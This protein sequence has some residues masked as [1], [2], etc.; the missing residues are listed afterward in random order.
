MLSL[1][2]VSSPI[3]FSCHPN[4]HVWQPLTLKDG[5]I[6]L[7]VRQTNIIILIITVCEQ[8]TLSACCDKNRIQIE[9][10]EFEYGTDRSL[11]LLGPVREA[12]GMTLPHPSV[13]GGTA[14]R[15]NGNLQVMGGQREVSRLWREL[16]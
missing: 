2:F 12:A 16:K 5:G 8:V 4:A 11:L 6:Y 13:S 14:N 7:T 15:H 3:L 9:A 1:I 10:N